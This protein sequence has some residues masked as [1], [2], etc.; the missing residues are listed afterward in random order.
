M[1]KAVVNI[2]L[3]LPLLC[4]QS[5]TSVQDLI[6]AGQLPEA[7]AQ[8]AAGLAQH[9]NDAGLLN[10]R[11]VIHAQRH[12]LPQALQDFQRAVALQPGLLPAWRNLGR[13]CQLTGSP[14]AASAW[15]HVLAVKPGDAE[16]RFSLAS[17]YEQQGRFSDS[18]RELAK[19]SEQEAA[20]A[21]ALALRCADLAGLH[22]A[23][24][25]MAVG[26]QAETLDAP[27][28]ALR[29]VVGAYEQ[30]ERWSDARKVLE[31]VAALEPGEAEHLFELARVAY[32]MNDFEG[33]L[34]YLGH[35]RDLA[36]SD[37]RVHFLFGMMLV[38]LK[39]PLE[40]RKS[41]EKALELDPR[42]PDFNYAMG[43]IVLNAR[44]AAS[45]LPYFRAYVAARPAD[46]RG[47]FA[48]GVAD[49]AAGDYENCRTEMQAVSGS[50]KT[51][52]GAAYFLGRVARIDEN[53]DE[54]ATQLNRAISLAPSF[55]EAFTELARV[56]LR[57]DRIQE[58][59]AA[60]DHALSIRPDSF[61]ANSV[62][63]A[64]YQRTHDPRAAEQSARIQKL[65]EERGKAMELM[66]RSIEVKPY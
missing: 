9:P 34:G 27:P 60:V 45:A 29:Q 50:P 39:L 52:I 14:C 20:E 40:A 41:V 8:V 58:A 66:L 61:Q 56:R 37:P 63:L 49:Y 15:Q 28:A 46:P 55:A 16:A 33:A 59:E 48:L 22:R 18:L 38:E 57:Q 5:V 44:D 19:L 13:S 10:L 24:E 65:D 43:S 12:E 42:N 4:G 51:Q 7:F 36:P 1:R 47:H 21:S 11:G 54:A 17:I 64:V 3:W 53:L 62:L 30:L 6:Q 25:A 26:A 2:A 23:A 35:A 32:K 31:R